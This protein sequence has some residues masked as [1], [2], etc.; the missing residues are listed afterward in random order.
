MIVLLLAV[1][2]DELAAAKKRWN[3]Y[4]EDSKRALHESI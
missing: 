3:T 1:L 4:R 2:H